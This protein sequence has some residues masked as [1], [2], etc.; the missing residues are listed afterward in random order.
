[1]ISHELFLKALN[2]TNL[3]ISTISIT[4]SM[5]VA[6]FSIIRVPYYAVGYPT[7]DIVLIIMRILASIKKSRKS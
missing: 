4:T 7:N 2:T 5:I 1:M 3:I 6:T